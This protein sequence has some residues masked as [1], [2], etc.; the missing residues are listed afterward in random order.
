MTKYVVWIDDHEVRVFPA[1]DLDT[2]EVP[3]ALAEE[4]VEFV[5]TESPTLAEIE[6]W[7]AEEVTA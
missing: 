3:E 4:F 5:D 7:I 6:A 2:V 1:D